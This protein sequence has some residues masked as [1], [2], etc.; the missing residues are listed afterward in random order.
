MVTRLSL[1]RALCATSLAA[2][3]LLGQP[4][5]AHADEHAG[6]QEASDGKGTYGYLREW[7]FGD[8]KITRGIVNSKYF[9]DA[10]TGAK[11]FPLP[12]VKDALVLGTDKASI[13]S[14]ACIRAWGC[15]TFKQSLEMVA[16]KRDPAH[17]EMFVG[18]IS[19]EAIWQ[20]PGDTE[21]ALLIRVLGWYADKSAI[22]LVVTMTTYGSNEHTNDA[23]EAAAALLGVWR[24]KSMVE[25]CKAAFSPDRNDQRQI[26]RV[27]HTCAWYLMRVGEGSDIGA[28]L[29]RAQTGTGSLD[30]IAGAALGDVSG[31]AEW[32]AAVKEHAKNP[33]NPAHSQA[34]VALAVSGDKGAE[35]QIVALLTGK[36]EDPAREHAMLLQ[37]YA[38]TEVGKRVVAGAKKAIAKLP[39][40]GLAAQTKALLVGLAL[41]QGDEAMV[42]EAKAIFGGDNTETRNILAQLLGKGNYSG[43]LEL[44]SNGLAGGAPIAALEPVLAEAFSMESD[45]SV[46]GWIARAWAMVKVNTAK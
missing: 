15:G 18:A 12:L 10:I 46:R 9:K 40:K 2:V 16:L 5:T 1:V 44:P 27:R 45:K 26:N 28:R 30:L 7:L 43:S 3:A 34:L 8:D 38:D 24:D 41:R 31:K 20:G 4:A 33:G 39:A 32:Q 19:P 6:W 21:R 17:K 13:Q 23:T 29:K 35:K 36:E 22:P 25:S 11:E 37:T 42:K 14:Q